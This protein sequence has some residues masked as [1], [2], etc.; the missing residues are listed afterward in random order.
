MLFLGLLM[1][2]IRSLTFSNL[3]CIVLWGCLSILEFLLKSFGDE[4]AEHCNIL[5]VQVWLGVILVL[6]LLFGLDFN[7][8]ILRCSLDKPVIILPLGLDDLSKV[9]FIILIL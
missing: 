1:H 5:G 4:L 2:A 6:C 3:C 9:S 8:S 7:L